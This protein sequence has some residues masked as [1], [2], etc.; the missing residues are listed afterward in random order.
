MQYK[1]WGAVVAISLASASVAQ[2]AGNCS[3]IDP[4]APGSL[5]LMAECIATLQSKLSETL[6]EN[7]AL[8]RQHE[9]AQAETVQL[10]NEIEA[11]NR[12]LSQAVISFN[13]S[14]RAGG[15]C[16]RGW[17]LF[18]PAGGRV[19]V[20]AGQHTND[21]LNEYPSYADDPDDATGG[22]ERV[23][24][25]LPEIPAHAHYLLNMRLAFDEAP[26]ADG[27][28]PGSSFADGGEPGRLWVGGSP[29][30]RRQNTSEAGDGA[31]HNNMP[32]YIALY[33]CKKD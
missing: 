2:E 7:S 15:A 27:L 8:E 32:P 21:G 24:L 16:P 6:A 18:T 22:E 9:A 13:R 1:A 3:D 20:G 25:K 28:T 29:I 12:L 5:T 33:F 10:A 17:S 19:I 31:A 26:N 4:S 14:E 11:I 30:K 23:K